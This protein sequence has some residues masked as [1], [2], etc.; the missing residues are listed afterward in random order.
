MNDSN[1]LNIVKIVTDCTFGSSTE[2][3]YYNYNNHNKYHNLN[4]MVHFLHSELK[5]N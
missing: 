5:L 4:E 3:K 2:M 1:Y